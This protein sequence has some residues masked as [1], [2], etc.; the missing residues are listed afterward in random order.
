[1]TIRIERETESGIQHAGGG[2]HALSVGDWFS[3]NGLALGQGLLRSANVIEQYP[4]GVYVSMETRKIAPGG[5]SAGQQGRSQMAGPFQPH[6]VGIW[7][8]GELVRG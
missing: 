7:R 4:R 8:S 3:A 6:C 5:Q 2:H 1:M